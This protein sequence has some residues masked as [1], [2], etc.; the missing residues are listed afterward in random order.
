M[1]I[2]LAIILFLLMIYIDFKRGIKLFLSLVFNFLILIVI[3]YMIVLGLNPIICAFLACLIISYIIL[4]FVNGENIKTEC[5]LKSVIIVLIILAISIFIMTKLSRIAG[6]G[7]ESTEE[8]SMFSYDIHIDFTSISICLILISLIG[9][10]VDASIAIS[11]ALYE[12]Y[13]NN[14]H[15]EFKELFKSGMNIGKDILCTTTNTL[16]FVFLGDFMTLMIWFY[17]GHYSFLEIMSAK[18]FVA[19][20]IKIMFSAIG[21]FLVIPITSYITTHS[22][23]K[24]K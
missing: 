9:A 6:F 3:F 24:K 4:Y 13:Q 23:L 11:S 12:V 19:E 2:V 21:C 16:L 5:S 15:L 7:Y 22:L 10:T 8:I 17:H 20:F 14:K 18:T 1:N